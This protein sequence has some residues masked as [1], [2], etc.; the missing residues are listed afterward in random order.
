MMHKL[1]FF[2][3]WLCFVMVASSMPLLYPQSVEI[4]YRDTR[5]SS[6]YADIFLSDENGNQNITPAAFLENHRIH[7]TISVNPRSQRDFFRSDDL[8]NELAQIQLMQ[9]GRVVRRSAPPRDAY[10]VQGG[11]FQRVIYYF[12][13][14]DVKV[15]KPFVFVNELDTTDAITLPEAFFEY[16]KHYHEIYEKAMVL[17]AEQEYLEAFKKLLSIVTDAVDNPE[18]SYYSFYQDASEERIQSLIRGY[19]REQRELY[20]KTS[21]AFF[22]SM[23]QEL[24]LKVDSLKKALEND[25]EVFYDYFELEYPGSVVVGAEYDEMLN[26]IV[27]TT[28]ESFR[29]FKDEQLGFFKMSGSD[30]NDNKFTTYID[31][32]VRMLTHIKEY[33]TLETTLDTLNLEVLARKPVRKDYRQTKSDLDALHQN[34]MVENSE[35]EDVPETIKARLERLGWYDD[36]ALKVSLINQDIINHGYVFDE[37]TMSRLGGMTYYQHQPYFQILE[38][39]NSKTNSIFEFSNSLRDA[40]PGCSDAELLMNIDKWLICHNLTINIVSQERVDDINKGLEQINDGTIWHIANRTFTTITAQQSN[41]A[42]PHFYL[43][44]SHFKMGHNF[45]ARARIREALELSPRYLAPRL[46]F[47][48]WLSENGLYEELLDETKDAINEADI[49]AFHYWRARALLKS[50]EARL[51]INQI[52]G[53]CHKLNQYDVYSWFLLGDAYKAIK[54]YRKAR[55]MYLHTQEMN[56]L[57]YSVPFNEKMKNLPNIAN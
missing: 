38:A 30:Y 26:Y 2:R 15:Y 1:I 42:I 52:K 20:D 24:L 50:G 29:L 56:P 48:D 3:L 28:V 44:V 33:K 40:L 4:K 51:A 53:N 18:I 9:E 8:Q 16:F 14:S 37:T 45:V 41:L 49:F 25:R 39:F 7:F 46:Y 55:E 36:L 13:K 57:D 35:T 12:D 47:F 17:Q 32:I 43:A 10:F 11:G 23:T 21:E 31:A 6:F 5:R 19:I 27:E 22:N 54:N 34:T